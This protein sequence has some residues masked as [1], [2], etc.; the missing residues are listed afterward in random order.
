L[1]T[2]RLTLGVSLPAARADTPNIIFILADD[3]YL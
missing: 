1:L 2:G 3:N